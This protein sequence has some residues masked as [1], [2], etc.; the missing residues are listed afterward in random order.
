QSR[1]HI[2]ALRPNACSYSSGL[3]KVRFARNPQS[4]ARVSVHQIES[5]QRL[6]P[7]ARREAMAA[8]EAAAAVPA[9]QAAGA[10]GAPPVSGATRRRRQ[11]RR[12]E[13]Q[14]PRRVPSPQ[15]RWLPPFAWTGHLIWHRK[16]LAEIFYKETWWLCANPCHC[17][18]YGFV[19]ASAAPMCMSHEKHC[20]VETLCQ[21]EPWDEGGM[22]VCFAI[23][24]ICCFVNHSG[25]G[26]PNDG[27]PLFACCGEQCDRDSGLSR[28]GRAQPHTQTI[29]VSKLR[30]Y[31]IM[32]PNLGV[33]CSSC[34]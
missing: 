15:P 7:D 9:A 31:V 3:Q 33:C 5:H 1:I 16:K 8:A 13:A 4:G 6:H 30:P 12:P 19:S 10:D 11:V 22:G 34:V 27:V 17:G 18:G 14:R 25:W 28:Q 32:G 29:P 21:S 23:S 2:P 20:C 26:G 24:K